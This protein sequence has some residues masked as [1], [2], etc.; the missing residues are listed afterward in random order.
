[1]DSLYVIAL[2]YLRKN[3]RLINFTV[4]SAEIAEDVFAIMSDPYHLSIRADVKC[5]REQATYG[6]DSF[7]VEHYLNSKWVVEI[8]SDEMNRFDMIRVG[9]AGSRFRMTNYGC[10]YDTLTDKFYN[11]NHSFMR[12]FKHGIYKSEFNALM[13]SDS[14]EG[15]CDSYDGYDGYDSD[16]SAIVDPYEQIHIVEDRA[17][18]EFP[19][20]IEWIEKN[21]QF[22]EQLIIPRRILIRLPF[23]D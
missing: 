9:S 10:I 8:K 18:D 11:V 16:N 6:I 1:M 12:P 15:G 3:Y 5:R 22:A 14:S 17:F 20:L 23:R 4:L 7:I 21:M 13:D 2:Q 19:G